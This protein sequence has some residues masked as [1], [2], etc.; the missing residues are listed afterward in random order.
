MTTH[1]WLKTYPDNVDWNA[2]LVAKPLYALLD[3]AERQWP[4]ARALEFLGKSLTY[5]EVA[6]D[7]RKMTAALLK[8][9]VKRGVKVGLCL[10]NCPQAVIAYFAILKTGATVV[11]FSP[12]YGTHEMAHQINDSA[13][14]VMFTLDLKLLYPK[15]A[16]NLGTTKLKKIIVTSMT[17]ALPLA[18]RLA[19]P[20]LKRNEI[21]LVPE[22]SRHYRWETLLEE[23]D[24][25][26]VLPAIHPDSDM[27][28]LQY[29]GGTT[30]VP[31]G[32]VLTHANLYLNAL[33]C[34]LWF[35]GAERGKERIIGVL[36]FFH[37]FAM[38]TIMNFGIH[39]GAE[40]ILHPR[41]ELKKLLEDITAK[42]PT[43]LPGV[44]TLFT[45]VNQS[46][47]LH[48]Y[49]LTSLKYCISGGAPLPVEVKKQ[50]EQLTACV[51]VE[52]YGLSESSP[53]VSCNPLTGENKTGSI[54]LPFPG[55]VLEVIDP[56]HP[57]KVLGIRETGEI[58]IRGPQVMQGYWQ[59]LDETNNVLKNGRLHTG[60]IGYMDEDGY[61]FIVDR[62][63]E[64][65]ISG[66]FN[67]Y[68]RHVEEAIYKHDAIAECAVIGMAHEKR[69]EVPKAFVVLKAGK[70]TT[71][72][73]LIEFL[74]NELPSYAVP[75]DI[76]LRDALPKTMVG[77]VD[78]K[79]LKKL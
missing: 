45:A 9:G 70:N 57:D 20:L 51:L 53:V 42:K 11:N 48:K 55:T 36:P 39:I 46:K 65:I 76:H 16:E 17:D 3:D 18:K 47:D 58:C 43:L 27:A 32:V 25:A 12:L 13:T 19:F 73:E 49:K 44:P 67:I 37:V 29:T 15:V 54:G 4:Q 74:K 38:T 77:K 31:K 72:A 41:F 50:F 56:D 28:V 64:L 69:G 52:G 14:E 34:G 33:Q 66:G 61:F 78:K 6:A 5:R 8:M 21:A 30:G 1:P 35:A 62:L 60:D 71:T 7:V 23:N 2:K 63:K 24:E 79:A 10:P 26:R 22:D 40:I 75:R 59:S 68:P